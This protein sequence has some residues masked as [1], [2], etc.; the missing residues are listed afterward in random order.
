LI[1]IQS[2]VSIENM[3]PGIYILFLTVLFSTLVADVALADSTM[4]APR[5]P[6]LSI[7]QVVKFTN[8]HC[9]G[10]SKNGT[11]FTRQECDNIGG[12]QDGTCADGFGV[13]CTVTLTT[14]GSTSV[15]NSYIQVSSTTNLD[16]GTNKY[17]ICPCSDDI[18]R[19][20]FDFESFDIQGPSSGFV[21]TGDGSTTTQAGNFNN[22]VGQCMIDTFQI[23]SPSGRGSPLV[24]GNNDNQHMIMDVS[25]NE[26]LTVDLGIGTTITS[27]TRELDIRIMQYRC[28]EEAGGPP[29][30]LQYFEN[31]TGKIR[32]FNFPDASPGTTITAGYAT[33]LANQHYSAC[34]RQGA[35]K[36]V[37]CYI[38]CTTTDGEGTAENAPTSQPSFGLSLSPSIETQAEGG[39]DSDC[40]TDYLWIPNGIKYDQFTTAI[41]QQDSPLEG[42]ETLQASRYCGRYFQTVSEAVW[43]AAE[44]SSICSYVTPFVLGVDF[45]NNEVCE[46]EEAGTGPDECEGIVGDEADEAGGAGQLGFSL[47]YVQHTPPI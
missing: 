32:S 12:I 24:C 11:C 6:K 1:Q 29:G 9:T 19:I 35:G 25:D 36:E 47:C 27:T 3:G 40:S 22:V 10:T 46:A 42:A 20:K 21:V 30:C 39:Q 28:G 4:D 33:H 26:C 14:S 15:N 2:I 8:S 37:I 16:Q 7:F 43:A 13:C 31:T 23:I 18:C 45:D 17:T 44:P 38:P 34:I 41:S 5:D